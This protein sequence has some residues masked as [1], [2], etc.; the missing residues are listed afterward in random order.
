M[1]NTLVL[2]K[3][4]KSICFTSFLHLG[5]CWLSRAYSIK[6]GC[7]RYNKKGEESFHK[8]SKFS[9]FAMLTSKRHA[10]LKVHAESKLF[11]L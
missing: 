8:F 11:Y 9:A 7:V 5:C 6:K 2:Q 1:S 3:K 10:V 4:L